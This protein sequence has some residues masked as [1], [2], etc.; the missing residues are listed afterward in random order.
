[1]SS[2]TIALN[3]ILRFLAFYRDE[4]TLEDG[5]EG[6]SLDIKDIEFR[7]RNDAS[8]VRNLLESAKAYSYKDLTVL[9]LILCS[10]LYPQFSIA[11]EFNHAK[12]PSEQMFH[13]RVK[14]FNLLH[15]NS[16]FAS[17]PEYLTLEELDI[18]KVATPPDAHHNQTKYPFSTKHQLLVYMSLLETNKPYVVN[19]VRMPA[20]QTLLLFS[21]R[22]ET[23][24]DFS[25]LVFDSWIEVRFGGPD[26]YE[27]L[28]QLSKAFVLRQV[29]QELL[30]MRLEDSL[31]DD[32]DGEGADEDASG[33]AEAKRCREQELE[34]V[35]SGGLVEFIHS[36]S[37]MSMRRLMPGDLKVIY[38]RKPIT[39]ISAD[40]NPF[41]SYPRVDPK[42]DNEKGGTQLN[43]YILYNCL[44]NEANVFSRLSVVE[45][46]CPVC[47]LQVEA[48][49]EDDV[50]GKAAHLVTCARNQVCP[51]RQAQIGLRQ[52]FLWCP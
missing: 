12:G 52:L 4:L 48:T 29:W 14:P 23:N 38:N 31:K 35:L 50:L 17:N 34:T 1:M 11:D 19:S 46:T 8:K 44:E 10:G 5:E 30:T 2:F 16:I 7:M 33:D 25:R 3:T 9:K 27:G 41:P 32:A 13:T 22:I 15:P 37:L 18:V 20:L 39:E 28:N 42:P 21:A 51:L 24:L 40:T 47:G 36:E 49:G 6:G 43:D 26:P 45:W